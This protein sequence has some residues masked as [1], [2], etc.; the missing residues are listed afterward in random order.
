MFKVCIKVCCMP[1]VAEIGKLLTR[2][3]SGEWRIGSH[4]GKLGRKKTLDLNKFAKKNLQIR[5]FFFLPKIKKNLAQF[6]QFHTVGE[7]ITLNLQLFAPFL[8]S[9]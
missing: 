3:Y 8:V 1:A 2:H 6:Y 4:L 5:I 9:I 7:E